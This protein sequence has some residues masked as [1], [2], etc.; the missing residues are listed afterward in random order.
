MAMLASNM[1]GIHLPFR[2]LTKPTSLYNHA[3]G[4]G[5]KSRAWHSMRRME[6]RLVAAKAA[7]AE[8]RDEIPF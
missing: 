7:Q 8:M 1:R 5:R 3:K 6:T 4:A 2:E